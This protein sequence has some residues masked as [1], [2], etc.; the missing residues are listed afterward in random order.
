[1]ARYQNPI[2]PCH[3]NIMCTHEPS[4]RKTS[5]EFPRIV[6]LWT[7]PGLQFARVFSGLALSSIFVMYIWFYNMA[8]MG[9]R[10]P[11]E[12]SVQ[13][14]HYASLVLHTKRTTIALYNKCMQMTFTATYLQLGIR[15]QQRRTL[16]R[17]NTRIRAFKSSLY[18]KH[19]KASLV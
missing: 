15:S 5:D 14:P 7:T 10:T 1:M 18:Y 9:G 2:L 3:Y 16:D 13:G 19:N 4:I 8:T 17:A 6:H 12:M 11:Y